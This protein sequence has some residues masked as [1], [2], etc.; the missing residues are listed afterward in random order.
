MNLPQAIAT[1]NIDDN[2]LH[3]KVDKIVLS[4]IPDHLRLKLNEMAQ[5]RALNSAGCELRFRLNGPDLRIQFDADN[6]VARH[7]G[8][9][10]SQILF[11]DFSH[12]YLHQTEGTIEYSLE[13]PD[14][15]KL[16]S[17]THAESLFNPRVV[18][19]LLPTHAC[20]SNIV[21]EG[22]I[23][24]LEPN[25]LPQKRIL[26]YGSS[27][28]QGSGALSS[29]ET[30]AAICAHR[31]GAD[32][33]NLGFGGSCHCEPEMADYLCQRD[34]FDYMILETGINMLSM[35]PEIADERISAL[36]HKVAKAH[37]EKPIFCLGVFPCRNDIEHKYKGRAQAIRELVETTVREISSSNLHF[38]QG[39]R[40]VTHPTGMTA[41][42]TH[43]AQ[44]GMIEIGNYVSSQIQS[45]LK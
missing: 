27:I 5:L 26:N 37:P 42:L 24:P 34:D 3:P 16:E 11:G 17:A 6:V 14:F 41:D 33:I 21:I 20:V 38:I 9:G 36:I 39:A 31:L 40:A 44:A 45:I 2:I 25:D 12:T 28:T 4:R 43:P 15:E 8:G 10:L 35:D 13:A 22:A 18:R 32:L 19:L 29:R 7:H 30:W 23:A 1:H